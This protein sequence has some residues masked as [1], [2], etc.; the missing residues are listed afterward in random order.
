MLLL[1]DFSP[2][3]LVRQAVQER[4]WWLQQTIDV[5]FMSLNVAPH[6]PKACSIS[7]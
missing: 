5:V 6:I 2:Q 4:D 1:I 7:S 3:A